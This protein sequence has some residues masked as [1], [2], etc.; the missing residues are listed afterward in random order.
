MTLAGIVAFVP[1][2]WSS[3]PRPRPSQAVRGHFLCR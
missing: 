3:V 2:P 1:K